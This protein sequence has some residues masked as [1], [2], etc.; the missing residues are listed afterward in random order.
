MEMRPSRFLLAFFRWY[1]RPAYREE[2]EGDLLQRFYSRLYQHG[3]VK[4]RLLF[5]KDILSLFRPSLMGSIHQ[6]SFGL[7]P[8]LGNQVWIRLL[9]CNLAF[10]ILA[11]LPFIPGPFSQVLLIFSFLARLTAFIGVL[12]IPISIVWLGFETGRIV[13]PPKKQNN[14]NN[15]YYLAITA[16]L[17]ALFPCGVAVA[18]TGH[19]TGPG[20]FVISL[21]IFILLV[22]SVI[23]GIKKMRSRNVTS[24]NAVPLYLLSVPVVVI[25]VLLWGA[26]PVSNYSRNHAINRAGTIIN[27]LEE[28]KDQTGRYPQALDELKGDYLKFLPRPGVMGVPRFEYENKRTDYVLSFVQMQHFGATREVVMYSKNNVY[29]MKGH[30]ASFDAGEKYWKYFWLD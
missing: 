8:D 30:F 29:P 1:C 2:I 18:L 6:L 22:R 19:E 26:L 16:A 9:I 3:A 25:V 21:F 20:G 5:A 15:G 17:L 7:I 11:L 4:S 14:W 12:L 28:Y 27:A 24:F 13:R 23:P 10:A